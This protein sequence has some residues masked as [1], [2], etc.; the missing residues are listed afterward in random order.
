MQ[1]SQL[2]PFIQGFREA[3]APPW[4]IVIHEN[5]LSNR[6]A[7]SLL[8]EILQDFQAIQQWFLRILFV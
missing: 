6:M 8:L 4:F 7:L 1:W 2:L 3:G 5:D